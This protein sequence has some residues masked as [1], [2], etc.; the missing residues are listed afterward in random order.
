MG[1]HEGLVPRWHSEPT[2][3]ND[4]KH[5]DA[6][7]AMRQDAIDI[8]DGYQKSF[9]NIKT[10]FDELISEFTHGFEIIDEQINRTEAHGY[11]VSK[12]YY[13]DQ[14]QL[15]SK[16]LT[17]QKKHYNDLVNARDKAVE[18]GALPEY[19]EA[20]YNMTND[21][22]SVENEV[23]S[24]ATQLVTLDKNIRQLS[25]DGFDWAIERLGV[26]TDEAE[27]LI[28]LLDQH[29]ILTETGQFNERGWAS[30]GLH[31]I[32]YD[33]YMAKSVQYAQQLR[34][35]EK[36]MAKYPY[37]KELI[38]R[39]EELLGLQQESIKAAEAEKEAVRDLV[40]QA[41]NKH[42]EKL[43]ELIDKYKETLSN[44]KD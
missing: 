17:E 30:V 22:N 24:L 23:N 42:L 14:K 15:V 39:R 9:D 11:F 25:W 40:E 36:Q 26:I 18:A 31:A 27:F 41:I 44:A 19:S 10:Q 6:K 2:K 3:D 4:Q 21:I 35:I 38:A 1:N 13:Q 33:T 5:V 8:G 16:Q 12:K 28:D 34:D 43:S 32:E 29:D 37:D 7:D 20:W